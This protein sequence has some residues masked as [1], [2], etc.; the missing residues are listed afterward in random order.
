[1]KSL[2]HIL[3]ATLL[4]L[5]PATAV[6]SCSEQEDVEADEY[7]N[8]R[9]RN[10]EYL[11]TVAARCQRLKSYS[12]DPATEGAIDDYVYYEVLEQGDG[13]DS[14]YYTDS[15]RISYRGRLIPTVSYPE[16]YVFD[17]T[18]SGTFDWRTTSTAVSKVSGYVEGFATALLYMH[19][20]DRWRL[21]IPQRMGYGTT[22]KTGIPAYSTLVFDVALIDFSHPGHP[23]PTKWN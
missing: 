6:V 14:P 4:L 10:E 20:G 18:Y 9:Q 22:E 7:A 16:G 11:S 21:Y 17:Q 2:Q 12:K 8:W 15:V 13:T 23:L 3:L 1:M 19:R 5:P